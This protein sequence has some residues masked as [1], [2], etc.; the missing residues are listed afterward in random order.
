MVK[1]LLFVLV[2]LIVSFFGYMMLRPS[3]IIPKET[4]ISKLQQ[5]SSKF[6]NWKGLQIHYTDEGEGIPLLM[7]HGFSGSHRN[8]QKLTNLLDKD[9]YR[10]IRVDL[11]GFGLSDFPK[12]EENY[13]SMYKDFM[14]DFEAYL[15]LK[16]FYLIGNSMGGGLSL[17]NAYHHPENIK[18]LVLFASAGY[19]MKLA[20]KSAVR[21]FRFN[22]V[23]H[24]FVKGIPLFLNKNTA[25]RV[26]YN[27]DIITEKEIKVNNMIWN[28][29]GNLAAIFR[30]AQNENFPDEKTI[31]EIK[32]PTLVI[33]GKQDKILNVKYAG[34]FDRDIKDC[35]VIIYDSCGHAP[36]IEKAERVKKD[37]EIFITETN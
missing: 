10:I 1:K 3:L 33:W 9:K 27:S 31:K 6:Y 23:E 16:D 37:L 21:F 29:E 12:D 4:V 8:F 28:K 32:V 7:V 20:R 11:P 26:F 19:E 13:L 24:L 18:G 34:Y 15:H 35:K 22:F 14:S 25:S 2:S 36:M 17:V 5:P 30:L